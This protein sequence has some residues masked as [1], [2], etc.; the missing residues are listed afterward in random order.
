M[1]KL[2]L[3]ILLQ[4][5]VATAQSD[6][7]TWKNINKADKIRFLDSL[8]LYRV[9]ADVPLLQYSFQEDSLSRLRVHNIFRHVDSIGEIEFK[10]DIVE[11]L[12]YHWQEDW[13]LYD[14]KNVHP[15]TV[16][17]FYG[18][19]TARLGKLKEID[20]M[21]SELFHGWKNSPPHW[22]AML[23][24]DYQ[25][26]TIDWIDD[27]QYIDNGKPLPYRRGY[28]AALVLFSKDINKRR[29]GNR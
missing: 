9:L 16:L 5:L 2:I 18:E 20:D 25:Y 3:I 7:K 13:D 8:N 24:P 28:F 21:I 22:E 15:D 29:V 6:I 23:S 1:N 12:H 11:N 19:C 27:S 10:K 4:V 14:R 26:I 17:S